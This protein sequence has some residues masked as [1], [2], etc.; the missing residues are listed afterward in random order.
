VGRTGHGKSSTGNS[1]LGKD[2]FA[3]AFSAKSVTATT[4]WSGVNFLPSLF[5]FVSFK[6]FQPFQIKW[7]F[8]LYFL[9]FQMGIE[10]WL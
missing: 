2:K 4:G 10:I 5:R 1:I 6:G 7:N 8:H 3:V 9:Y